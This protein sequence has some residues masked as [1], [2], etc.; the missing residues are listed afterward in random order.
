MNE[1]ALFAGA[2]GGI[3]GTQLLGYTTVGACEIDPYC[4]QIL[5]ERQADGTL[6]PFAIWDDIRT[7]DPEPWK[8]HVDLISGGF[9]CTDISLAGRGEGLKGQHSSLWFEMA[10]I[11][12]AIR[13]ARAFLE[14][15]PALT[16]RGLG[17]I[18][19]QLAEI[20]YD[21][22]WECLPAS[23]VGAPHR[24]ERI[25][26]LA[27]NGKPIPTRTFP[28]STE[29]R[30]EE[31]KNSREAPDAQQQAS[32]QI[33]DYEFRDE[34]GQIYMQP[35]PNQ[36]ARIMADPEGKPIWP[37]LRPDQSPEEW[38]RRFSHGSG[39]IATPD[40]ELPYAHRPDRPRGTEAS[41]RAEEQREAEWRERWWKFE[42]GMGRVADG[43]AN[44]IHRLKALGN[45]Q[46]P[47][48]AAQAF[49]ILERRLNNGTDE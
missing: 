6:P 11:I 40:G 3:L 37:G 10:R 8:G 42:P 35:N 1:L 21:A 16:S 33:R 28:Y 15:T 19:G 24:R 39:K 43:V 31:R 38:R 45:G 26:I 12:R 34:R 41:R 49:R 5:L 13:P 18:L 20:G 47:F 14:N 22:E 44:R 9:P 27:G 7:F 32:E 2:G 48:Q 23:A 25:W 29:P 30:L 36:R 46:V 4:R 17:T